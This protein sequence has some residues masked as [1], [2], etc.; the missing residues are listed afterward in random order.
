MIEGLIK[1]SLGTRLFVFLMA[2]F[3]ACAGWY[4][5]SNL[6]IEAFP[7]PTDTQVQVITIYPGQPSEEVERRVSIP[8]ERALNGVPGLYRLRSISLF[9]LSL[10]TLTFDDGVEPLVARQQIME[11][12]PDANLPTGI[13]PDLGPLATPIGEVYRYTLEGAGA[14]PMTLRTVQDWVVRPAIMRVQGV[15]D[16]V[17]Y[18]GLVKEIHVEPDP[19]K[20]AALGV[21]LDDLFQALSKASQ[22]ASGGSIERGSEL[23]VIRSVG[24]FKSLQDIG[25]VRV[26]F[27]AGVPVKVSDVATVTV[28]FLPRQGVVTRGNNNDA[29]QGI[30]LMRRGMNPSVVLA[31]L[32]T[33]LEE[34]HA[35]ALPDGIPTWNFKDRG[36]QVDVALQTSDENG[37]QIQHP[38]GVF[39]GPCTAGK[40]D[41]ATLARATCGTIELTAVARG[42]EIAAMKGPEE[43]ARFRALKI[44]I[45]PFYDRTELVNTT[46]DT[47]FHNLG[48]GALLVSVVLFVFLLSVRASLVV[49]LVIPLSLAAS[50]IYLHVRGMSANLLSMGAVD[51]GIIVD[52]A[53]ILVEHVFGHA[54]GDDYQRQS[55]AQR[56]DTIYHAAR[57]V[58]KPTLFSLLII[59]AAYLPIFALQRVEGRIFAPMAH[60]VVSA[61]VGAMLVSFTLVPVLSF[62]AL[63][64]H[65]KIRESPVLKAARKAYDP[66]LMGAMRNPAAILIGALA[67]LYAGVELGPRLGTEFLPEL[68]EGA[69][70]VTFTL[71]APISLTEGRKLTPKIT[72]LMRKDRKPKPGELDE[73][74]NP[75]QWG[76]M[77]EVTELLTQLGRP[78]DGTDPTLPSNLEI[79]VK[80]RPMKEWRS[81][82]K[83]LDDVIE[84]MD[85][86]LKSIPGLEY[87]FSQPIRDNVAENISGQFG[88]VAVKIYGDDLGQLQT[89]AESIEGEIGKVAGVADL[90]IVRASEQPSI[91]VVPKREALTRWDLDLGSLQDYLET[92]LSGHTATDLWEAEKRFDVTVRLPIGARGSIEA[93]RNLRVPL[94]DGSIVP[95]K[96]LATV[97]MG[98]SRA[99]ITR[100]NGKRYVGIRM[101]VRNRDL[102]S[103]IAEAQNRVAAN[104]KLPV[105]Y[106]ILWGGEFENQQR[107]MKR[108]T[109]VLPLSLLL[110]FL[111]LF[112]AFGT[113][114]D[115]TIILLNLPVALIG[116]FVGLALVGMT[117]SVSAAVGFIALLGQA[118]LNGVLVVSAIR[119]RLD[120]GEDLWT[121]TIQ[122]ARERL[123]AIL[124]TALLAALGLLPA[125]M[126]HAIGSETQ[127]PI[128][129]VVVSGT[130]SSAILTLIVLPVSYYWAG[131][132]RNWFRQRRGGDPPTD[133][134]RAT[135]G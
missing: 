132:A 97:T 119:A 91:S 95:V 36:N 34:L 3:V 108:L 47:V 110:T 86:N 63:R 107:A 128:A 40:P 106:D 90:G 127:R 79:F 80:M 70:Y 57:E 46:L 81:Q 101:N 87:N 39:A 123:R 19:T 27:H 67:V 120:R 68:N 58:A 48:E 52:G 24:T 94:K 33:R 38:L 77:P 131:A 7:D 133:I 114:W 55:S 74:G 23:F 113:V 130:I 26:G 109:L 126:S 16:V 62:F 111:L 17:S 37:Q 71:P 72:A 65:K 29:V 129:V 60:T 115:A 98:S 88:Q 89:L 116:G 56:I 54:A 122:G 12:I 134:P 10:V 21:V 112:S 92:A 49:T 53:V 66:L 44:R 83:T 121:A 11:R 105:G 45:V 28:G 14:D 13:S 100:E 22:N 30:V 82:I 4:A 96:A 25:M 69:L 103:F 93:I 118:V 75:K 117:L 73:H 104:V 124:M 64:R 5:Y 31:G 43:L 84:I 9:G 61:L 41:P 6:T 51:F 59:V 99:V 102:G 35:R 32:R 15:A 20:M 78:E 50:F 85:E 135:A 1:S 2:I 8:L 125:A 18:G 42:D 76:D